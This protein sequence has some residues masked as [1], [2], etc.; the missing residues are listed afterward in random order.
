MDRG[1]VMESSGAYELSN[2]VETALAA[3][4][5]AAEAKRWA[6]TAMSTAADHSPTRRTSCA[7]AA[8]S[9]PSMRDSPDRTRT[10]ACEPPQRA[11][12]RPHPPSANAIN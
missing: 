2:V 6:Y 8:M 9:N 12:R 1:D 10:L 3:L 11:L 7:S 5:L 4:V